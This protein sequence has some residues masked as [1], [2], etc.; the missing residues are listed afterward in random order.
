MIVQYSLRVGNRKENIPFVEK[1]TSFL[2]RGVVLLSLV[3]QLDAE[4]VV[5]ECVAIGFGIPLFIAVSA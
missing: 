2:Y 3:I 1:R 4:N 5:C